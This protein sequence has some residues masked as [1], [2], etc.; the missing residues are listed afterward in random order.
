MQVIGKLSIYSFFQQQQSQLD[1]THHRIILAFVITSTY[2]IANKCK[3]RKSAGESFESAFLYFGRGK[4]SICKSKRYEARLQTC[5]A[6]VFL[7][8]NTRDFRDST[9][10]GTEAN[11][12]PPTTPTSVTFARH[13][14][15]M[16]LLQAQSFYYARYEV[17]AWPKIFDVYAPFSLTLKSI[18]VTLSTTRFSV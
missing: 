14:Q 15:Y 11:S 3:W 17:Y 4:S 13:K 10:W 16:L 5:M 6:R 9:T 12:P 7:C 8:N 2:S 1:P 18:V